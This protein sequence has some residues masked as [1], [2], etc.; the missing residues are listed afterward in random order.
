M[1]TR[2]RAVATAV[3]LVA[4]LASPAVAET[5]LN[6][7][8]STNTSSFYPYY[9]ALAN[10]ISANDDTLNVTVVS[11]GG[12]AANSVLL[13]EGD[14]DFGG[15]SPDIIADAE[16]EGYDGFRVLWWTL[17]AI[18]NLMATKASGITNVVEFDGECFHPGTNGSSQQK[19]MMRILKVLDIHPDLYMSDSGDAIDAIKNGRCDGLM[20]ATQA[21]RLDSAS[22]ELNLTRPLQ[23]LGYTDDQIAQIREALPWMGFYEMPAGVVE[24]SDP[25]TVHAV[26]IG[27]TATDRMDE[28]TA[29]RLVKGMLESLP[30]QRS[31]LPAIADVDIAQ[32]TLDVAEQP[33]HAGAVKAYRE[34]GYTVPDRLLPPEMK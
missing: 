26:W 10:G 24:G 7:G 3:L 32:Q 33:L 22:A 12:F 29:Y 23:P 8:G 17:P 14:L 18:Q 31:A 1:F 25:Y 2:F 4:P 28:D 15:I 19:N 6:M 30:L 5:Q 11:A 16:E 13:Q 9:S 20:M 27:F 21:P 34:A